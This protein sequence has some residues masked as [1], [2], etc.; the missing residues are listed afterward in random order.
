[1]TTMTSNTGS[2]RS[3][4]KFPQVYD[5][6]FSF[7]DFDAEVAQMLRWCQK[8]TSEELPERAIEF[9]SGPSRHAIA[10]AQHGVDAT[11]VDSSA[12]M[13]RYASRLAAAQETP[14]N[15]MQDD[16]VSHRASHK[17]GLAL[18]MIDSIAHLHDEKQLTAHFA[19]VAQMLVDNGL[20]VMETPIRNRPK[21]ITDWTI[22]GVR[23]S[24]EV[25][26]PDKNTGD[27]SQISIV[28]DNVVSFAWT[29]QE[30]TRKFEHLHTSRQWYPS[31]LTQ[32]AIATGHWK[33]AGEFGDFDDSVPKESPAAQRYVVVLQRIQ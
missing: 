4:Y 8:Y 3:V 17:Y 25:H 10:L 27:A 30:G 29:T 9:A 6:A 24:V 12:E 22:N 15:V 21:K 23:E 16:M 2:R 18:T 13:C 11:A 33:V 26:W 28:D 1:M 31:E 20:Y 19:N 14:L 7:R 32:H 5:L